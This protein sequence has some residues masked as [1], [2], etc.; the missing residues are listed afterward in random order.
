MKKNNSSRQIIIKDNSIAVCL[1]LTAGLIAAVLILAKTAVMGEAG[2]LYADSI[3]PH[4]FRF[5]VD[6]QSAEKVEGVT[7]A[8]DIKPA[9]QAPATLS[10]QASAKPEPVKAA[11]MT[12]KEET[13]TVVLPKANDPSKTDS[14]PPPQI[15]EP[16]AAATKPFLRTIRGG[17]HPQYAS[18]VFEFSGSIDYSRPGL[19]GEEI[20]LKIKNMDTGLRPYRKYRT[21][22]SWVKLD[23]TDS[24]LDVAIGVLPGLY[25]ISDFL[26][27]DPPR[28]VINLYDKGN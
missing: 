17:R 26:M 19:Q 24:G 4:V 2:R 6:T 10:P 14:Q 21:F 8:A 25:K 16:T 22:D 1:V 3:Q 7:A 18:I 5:K 15:S 12:P 11:P 20:R 27:E 13:A 23:R 28:L 9:G